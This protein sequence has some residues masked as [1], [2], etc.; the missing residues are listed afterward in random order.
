MENIK[1]SLKTCKKEDK[2]MGKKEECLV[3]W[4]MLSDEEQ[5]SVLEKLL[6]ALNCAELQNNFVNEKD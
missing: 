1:L 2:K 3:L 5:T 4:E 6:K